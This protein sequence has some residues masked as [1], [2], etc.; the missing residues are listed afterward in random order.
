MSKIALKKTPYFAI[1]EEFDLGKWGWIK[2]AQ[3]G[4][5]HEHRKVFDERQIDWIAQFIKPG[6]SA[7]DIGAFIGDTAIPMAVAAGTTGHILCFEP[8]PA[9]FEVLEL[10]ASWYSYNGQLATIHRCDS[11]IGI[12]AGEDVFHYHCNQ[13]NGGFMTDGDPVTVWRYRLDDL[14]FLIIEKIA[15]LKIDTEGED[16]LLLR[17]FTPWLR[18]H[19][20]PVVQVERYP[21]LSPEQEKQLWGAITAYGT[22]SLKDDWDFTP[23]NELPSTLV[24]I[25]IKPHA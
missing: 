23:L 18:E 7:I 6:D 1:V 16:G 10:N 15:F 21:H 13:I 12:T 22:P 20:N 19:G 11:A 24:D 4:H 9:S 14:K 25:I 2:F 3:W 5:P 8:N 17:E